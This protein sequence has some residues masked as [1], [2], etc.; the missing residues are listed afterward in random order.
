DPVNVVV[1]EKPAAP[2]QK[3]NDKTPAASVAGKSEGALTV[4]NPSA[5]AVYTVTDSNNNVVGSN[6]TANN[7]GVLLKEDG[8]P[9]TLNPGTYSVVAQVPGDDSS[10]TSAGSFT[11]KE[12]AATPEATNPTL[13]DNGQSNGQIATP[14][15]TA[16]TAVEY[17]GK[18][19]TDYKKAKVDDKGVLVDTE[20]GAPIPLA[21]GDYQVRIPANGDVLA[22]D[23]ADVRVLEKPAAPAGSATPSKKD[24]AEG[25]ITL[26]NKNDDATYTVKGPGT[27]TTTVT[28][29]TNDKGELVDPATG[30]PHVFTPGDYTVTATVGSGDNAAT[31]PATTIT[32]AEKPAAPTVTTTLSNNGANDGSITVTNPN[33]DSGV[34]Y[35]I[36]KKGES[37]WT[38]TTLGENNKLT[39][40]GGT[41]FAPGEYEVRVVKTPTGGTEVASDITPV[42]VYEAPA[43]PIQD[44]NNYANPAQTGVE[45]GADGQISSDDKLGVL[46][47]TNPDKNATYTVK[48]NAGTT[49]ATGKVNDKGELVD[50]NG[51]LLKF[52]HGNYT[53]TATVTDPTNPQS[54]ATS[55]AGNFTVTAKAKKP[56]GSANAAS[57]GQSNGSVNVDLA[58]GTTVEY[59]LNGG[60]WTKGTV[61]DGKLAGSDGTVLDSLAPKTQVRVRI[62]ADDTNQLLAS[63]PLEVTINEIP[64][65]PAGAGT[66]SHVGEK[67][68]EITLSKLP[69]SVINNPDTR[70]V[71]TGPSTSTGTPETK[72]YKV[73]TDGSLVDDQG[74]TPTFA[75]GTYSVS[76]KNGDGTSTSTSINVTPI[77][78]APEANGVD[79]TT[80]N[81]TDGHI[82]TPQLPKG[83]EVEYRPSGSD[84]N[85]YKK[86]KVGDNGQLVDDNG[87]AIAVPSGNYQVRVVS[88]TD[89]GLAVE[90]SD[91]T[92][93]EVFDPAPRGL[94][95]N[96]ASGADQKDGKITGLDANTT[97]QYR[98]KGSTEW[99]DVPAGTSIDGLAPGTY[100]VR[101]NNGTGTSRVTEL[102]V[103][104]AETPAAPANLNGVAVTKANANDGKITGL[105]GNTSYEYR[106]KGSTE[107]TTVPAGATTVENLA[108]GDYEVRVAAKDGNPASAASTVTVND[109]ATPEGPL[110]LG[111][112]NASTETTNDGK[113]TGLDASRT[114]EYRKQGS[115]EWISVPAGSTSINDL[116]PGTY[117]VRFA[118]SEGTPASA[119]VTVE[120]GYGEG[121]GKKP[122]VLSS[123]SSS[124][125][126]WVYAGAAGIGVAGLFAAATACTDQMGIVSYQLPGQRPTSY[127]LN[128]RDNDNIAPHLR[129]CDEHA[130]NFGLGRPLCTD[131]QGIASYKLAGRRHEHLGLS[132]EDNRQVAPTLRRCDVNETDT[133][134]PG[135][136]FCTD[137]NGIASRQLP[138]Q[139]P[140]SLGLTDQENKN[141]APR[142]GRCVE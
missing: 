124:I 40:N 70:I 39:E 94:D 16:G 57:N 91:P 95:S 30:Q 77:A 4:K 131:D 119:A 75:P 107:W 82:N 58:N 105:D 99:I 141:I 35:Q 118:A 47:V 67:E 56:Q 132:E 93:V 136:T 97:Y 103:A 2:V 10:K 65:A 120:V 26:S 78:K 8:T 125:P 116:L 18:N 45:V 111:G 25:V 68:G 98:P 101:T 59:Q 61:K 36:R 32:V 12:K 46:T 13:A 42:T 62:P 122:F 43:A 50:N 84:D 81:G 117:E 76:I 135:G 48:N 66:K 29:K 21:P 22:S 60:T 112:Q 23:P 41:N 121:N 129:R 88:G 138:G 87:A 5:G 3:D 108:P 20:S 44:L 100:E 6:L 102:T 55:D 123:G 72:E 140:E 7:D 79:T 110:D 80:T 38:D 27:D 69:Y 54:T 49:V 139:R 86:A 63:D 133:A 52:E 109:A 33:T 127:N 31:S 128:K 74:N 1:K 28:L 96:V 37:E 106:K 53:V 83:T 113:I 51:N 64:A 137:A 85:S 17:K 15:L 115:T 9:L 104:T 90:P 73:N 130:V 142:L 14:G 114:Y 126:W 89:N 134:G 24:T 34:K 19:D 11:V 71:V 92:E